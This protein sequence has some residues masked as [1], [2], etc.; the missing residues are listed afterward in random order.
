MLMSLPYMLI[1]RKCW[2]KT[3]DSNSMQEQRV[4]I[5][6]HRRDH[7]YKVVVAMR[8]LCSLLLS[9]AWEIL[10]TVKISNMTGKASSSYSSIFLIGWGFNV[11]ILGILWG[12]SEPISGGYRN[13][14]IL[15]T[16]LWY[17]GGW[18]KP[19]MCFPSL[20]IS[21]VRAMLPNNSSL[22]K[23]LICS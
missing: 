23:N 15:V 17:C 6:H 8:W 11:I 21:V 14:S 1:P 9:P 12:K 3:P 13:C 22:E 4:F 10:K 20:L 16:D 19:P 18:L 2:R 7:L 5:Y